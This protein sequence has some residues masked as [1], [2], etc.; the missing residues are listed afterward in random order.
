MIN[1]VNTAPNFRS[2]GILSAFVLPV[3]DNLYYFY[4][5][6]RHGADGDEATKPAQE[7]PSASFY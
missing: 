7:A 4:L 5:H 6:I 1:T 2:S 3:L